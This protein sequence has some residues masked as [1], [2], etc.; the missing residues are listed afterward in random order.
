MRLIDADALLN[1]EQTIPYPDVPFDTIGKMVDW[2][3]KLIDKQ[4]TVPAAPRW[5]RCEERLPDNNDAVNVVYV[6][7]NPP[8]YYADIKDKPFV[9]TAHY[10][11][12]K[13]WWF[14]TICQD[15]LDEYGE[16]DADEVDKDIEVLYW[17]P[18][19]SPPVNEKFTK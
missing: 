4:P 11:G 3:I 9:A 17:M 15:Y 16:S 7:R 18:L 8:S 13:W 1:S 5:V 19:P 6:N 2:F 14:S 12:G 10:H